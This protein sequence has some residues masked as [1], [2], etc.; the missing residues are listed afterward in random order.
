MHL[1]NFHSNELTIKGK[2]TFTVGLK[3]ALEHADSTWGSDTPFQVIL[4]TD[5]N[6]GGT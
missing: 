2:S 4:V 6:P 1:L 3:S 5:A